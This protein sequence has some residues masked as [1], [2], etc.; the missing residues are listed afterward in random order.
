MRTLHQLQEPYGEYR[1][2]YDD[3]QYTAEH[4][5]RHNRHLETMY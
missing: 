1:C 4:T 3:K 5:L 2:F